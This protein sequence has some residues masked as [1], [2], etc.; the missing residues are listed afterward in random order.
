MFCHLQR[1]LV[2]ER[3]EENVLYNIPQISVNIYKKDE[4]AFHEQCPSSIHLHCELS[5]FCTLVLLWEKLLL[6]CCSYS[7]HCGLL[8]PLPLL[9]KLLV[10]IA[11]S[12]HVLDYTGKCFT[13][14]QNPAIDRNETEQHFLQMSLF[15]I[16]MHFY[17]DS[18]LLQLFVNN[19]NQKS[20]LN[21]PALVGTRSDVYTNPF[22]FRFM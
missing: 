10:A 16:H 5:S 3:E 7:S 1:L 2:S 20:P 13:V 9:R 19:W 17:I 8:V 11:A 15:H 14:R 21:T 6:F 12:S 22:S 4:I 18:C